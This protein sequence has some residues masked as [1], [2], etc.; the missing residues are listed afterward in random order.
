MDVIRVG[1]LT[2]FPRKIVLVEEWK[3]GVN[4]DRIPPGGLRV[5]VD[6]GEDLLLIGEDAEDFRRQFDAL[7]PRGAR[8]AEP[9]RPAIIGRPHDPESG[10]ALPLS[11]EAVEPG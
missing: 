7:F 1:Y 6:N 3:E 9:G 11:R 5:R 10:R 8:A 2:L 4:D